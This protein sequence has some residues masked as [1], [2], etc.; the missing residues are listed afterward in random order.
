MLKFVEEMSDVIEDLAEY[1]RERLLPGNQL[2][3]HNNELYFI[4]CLR[5]QVEN[6]IPEAPTFEWYEKLLTDGPGQGD[7]LFPYL[8]NEASKD[9]MVWFL[10]QEAAGEAGFD[11]LV[12]MSQVKLPAQPKM[13]MARNYWDE[14][15]QGDIDGMHGRLLDG[16]IKYFEIT[17]TVTDTVWESLMMANMMTA[18]AVHRRYAYLAIGALGVIEMTAPGRVGQVDA[19]LARLGVPKEARRYFSLHAVLD[20]KHSREWNKEVIQPLS[21]DH[22][23]EMAEGAYLRLW[24]GSQCFAR[25]REEFGLV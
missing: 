13:E 9:E 17:P 14:M 12:A 23:R 15:G 1:N 20:V 3:P 22:M 19:G 16:V 8:A 21:G 11:D 25:Y 7:S 2:E 4:E 5:T 24:C 18:L 10:S 6:E